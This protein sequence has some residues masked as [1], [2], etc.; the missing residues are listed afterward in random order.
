MSH[1]HFLQNLLA[2]TWFKVLQVRETELMDFM[3]QKDK[4]KDSTQEC[5]HQGLGLSHLWVLLQYLPFSLASRWLVWISKLAL[6]QNINVLDSDSACVPDSY[7]SFF[8]PS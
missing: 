6:A 2:V 8:S 7:S 5:H 4:I 3:S 1:I